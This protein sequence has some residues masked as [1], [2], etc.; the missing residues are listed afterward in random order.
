MNKVM[1]LICILA[2]ASFTVPAD[3]PQ[4]SDVTGTWQGS[5]RA[6][7]RD[8]RTVVKIAK[9]PDGNL[10]AV[11]YSIDQG[12]AGMTASSVSVDRST[13]T[14]DITVKY[15]IGIINGSFEGTLSADG[16]TIDGK[17]SQNNHIV[18][19]TLV[20]ATPETAWTIPASPKPMADQNP[21]FQAVT[22]KPTDS[23]KLSKAFTV[24]DGQFSTLNTTLQDLIMFAYGIHPEQ[25]ENGP[26][27][28]A[29]DKYNL[30]GEPAGEGQPNE[31]Q[32]MIMVQKL[33]TDRF[34]LSF[35]H[36]QKMLD[37]YAIVLTQQRPKFNQS[38][39]DP[40]GLPSLFFQT[41]RR[42]SC[43]QCQHE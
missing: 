14:G 6:P 9:T 3:F 1:S 38:A 13:V 25:I 4:S 29:K 24:R 43:S 23:D 32:W 5:L 11:L 2:L 15:A 22:I 28:I 8:L 20:R 17:W 35:H 33:L 21:S 7:A 39:D 10:A 19:L 34:Q 30:L 40:N 12:A 31:Q 42:S 18:P 41:L 36:S 26:D 16:N 27:W 37:V